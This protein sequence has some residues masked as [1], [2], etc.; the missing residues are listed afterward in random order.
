[1]PNRMNRFV[2]LL[3][4]LVLAFT[5]AGQARAEAVAAVP[6]GGECI[7]CC[8]S[9]AADS[10]CASVSVCAPAMA[11]QDA[12][13]ETP[14]KPVGAWSIGVLRSAFVPLAYRPPAVVAVSPAVV[15][16]YLSFGRFLL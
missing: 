11:P 4:S 7:D 8:A 5:F 9:P 3:L 14:T 13:D 2:A 12:A 10:T 15:P 6:Q 16:S 1:M